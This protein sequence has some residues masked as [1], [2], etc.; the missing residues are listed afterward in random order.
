MDWLEVLGWKSEQLE[1]LRF[2]GYA[3]IRQG[4]YKTALSFFEALTVLDPSNTYDLQTLGA[5][6][7]QNGNNLMALNYI[8]KALKLDPTHPATLLNKAKA[9]FSL[10]YKKQ[11]LL[12]ARTLAKSKEGPIADQ[13]TALILAL[14]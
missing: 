3:Y 10:G 6:Y 1:D 12:A 14:S 4:Q 13:A 9:L 8:E 5:L 11:A 7:L 2:I